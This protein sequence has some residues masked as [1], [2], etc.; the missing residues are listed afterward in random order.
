MAI[1][2]CLNSPLDF[3]KMAQITQPL[4]PGEIP[5]KHNYLGQEQQACQIHWVLVI[6]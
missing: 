4:F 6:S 2:R 5:Q 3:R 1:L